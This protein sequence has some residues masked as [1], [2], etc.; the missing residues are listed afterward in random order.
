ML[1]ACR[2][3]VRS[4]KTMRRCAT[5]V[6]SQVPMLPVSCSLLQVHMFASYLPPMLYSWYHRVL[7]CRTYLSLLNLW[8]FFT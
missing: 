8:G 6:V 7:C 1:S 4:R 2:N 3:V 5:P